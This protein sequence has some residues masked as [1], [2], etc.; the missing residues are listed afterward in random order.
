MLVTEIAVRPLVLALVG[1]LASGVLG[2]TVCVPAVSDESV[3]APGQTLDWFSP[4][5]WASGSVPLSPLPIPGVAA[6]TGVS[7]VTASA[8][9]LA[10]VDLGIESAL[11]IRSAEQISLSGGCYR[12]LQGSVLTLDAPVIVGLDAE[13][14][15]SAAQK[16]GTP[17]LVLRTQ[18]LTGASLRIDTSM[19]AE[20]SIRSFDIGLLGGVISSR[21][22]TANPGAGPLILEP[23]AFGGFSRAR[24]MTRP[25]GAA[26]IEFRGR[27]TQSGAGGVESLRG[28]VTLNTVQ[29]DGGFLRGAQAF[30]IRVT[31]AAS[32]A[33]VEGFIELSGRLD[34]AVYSTGQV[35]VPAGAQGVFGPTDLIEFEP[36]SLTG[37]GITLTQG[38][39]VFSTEIGPEHLL[40]VQGPTIGSLFNLGRIE[41]GIGSH[42]LD[43]LTNESRVVLEPG[44][45]LLVTRELVQAEGGVIELLGNS[46]LSPTELEGGT[47]MGEVGSLLRFPRSGIARDVLIDAPVRLTESVNIQ[48][49]VVSLGL[50]ESPAGTGVNLQGALDVHAPATFDVMLISGRLT[51][52]APVVIGKLFLSGSNGEHL[53]TGTAPV[54][55]EALDIG[56]LTLGNPS[57][58]EWPGEIERARLESTQT[59]TLSNLEEVRVGLLEVL[60]GTELLLEN[61]VVRPHATEASG[62]IATDSRIVF[63]PG[64]VLSERNDFKLVNSTLVA[65]AS[66][67]YD[68]E[69]VSNGGNFWFVDSSIDG[70][71]TIQYGRTVLQ[72]RFEHDGELRLINNRLQANGDDAV[73]AGSGTIRMLDEAGQP[74]SGGVSGEL[75]HEAGHTIIGGVSAID[76]VNAGELDLSVADFTSVVS[77]VLEPTS[78]IRLAL[79]DR[80]ALEVRS[81]EL[82]GRLEIVVPEGVVLAAGDVFRL[83]DVPFPGSAVITGEFDEIVVPDLGGNLELRVER[84]GKA[85][86]ATVVC[87][88]DLNE[89]RVLDSGDIR[90]YIQLWVDEDPAADLN[91]DGVA[92]TADLFVYVS[93]FHAGC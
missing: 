8:F 91:G 35:L 50:W 54:R 14:A 1:G 77:G 51:A 9:G 13:I 19:E 16:T 80:L 84:D 90:S 42:E 5:T 74:S 33:R 28:P 18:E 87:P 62:I 15:F 82:A 78:V 27:W 24:V 32:P 30:P 79:R 85:Y 64:L 3:S 2:Q 73:L 46:V 58:I 61:L 37:P 81:I 45:E 92:D 63:G 44:A 7:A 10:G 47:V 75:R 89:D 25:A 36:S 41:F 21:S 93:R 26:L 43:V 22:T 59:I 70:D 53:I 83:I 23:G 20:G 6:S 76:L 49:E 52:F 38:T 56:L 11:G 29:F 34:G 40:I 48:G 17:T 71:L 39:G 65:Q 69:S 67:R 55:I 12:L 66:P 4:A 68:L 72:G 86:T 57:Q 60:N 31:G 88:V